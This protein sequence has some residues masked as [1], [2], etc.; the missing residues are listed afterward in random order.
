MSHID[1][2]FH[3]FIEILLFLELDR[4]S[5]HSLPLYGET[6]ANEINLCF[7]KERKSYKFVMT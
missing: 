6:A 5:P 2:Y 3:T 7:T 1:F 4:P